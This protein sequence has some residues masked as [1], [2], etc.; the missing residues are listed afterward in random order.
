MTERKDKHTHSGSAKIIGPSE[1]PVKLTL[2][3]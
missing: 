3:L 1:E 2:L